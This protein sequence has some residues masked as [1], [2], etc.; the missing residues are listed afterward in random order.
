MTGADWQSQ[1]RRIGSRKIMG[2][3]PDSG[4]TS[5]TRRKRD[6]PAA[7]ARGP[8]IG[9]PLPR[10]EDLRFVRGAGRFT[11][12][13]ALDGQAYAAFVR[14]P[15]AHARVVRIDG[16][17]AAAPAGVLAILTGADYAA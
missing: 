13:V 4:S 14:S 12:D 2:R 5:V 3:S 1:G 6:A 17:R 11:D 7:H 16:Q 8:F 9:R 10:F 15:H